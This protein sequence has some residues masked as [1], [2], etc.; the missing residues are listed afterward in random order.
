MTRRG[1]R[2]LE[3]RREIAI[4][5]GHD[6]D[7]LTPDV[8]ELV[9]RIATLKLVYE[10]ETTKLVAGEDVDSGNLLK[11]TESLTTLLPPPPPKVNA[12]TIKYVDSD[13][14]GR[15][16]TGGE[17]QRLQREVDEWRA[18]YHELIKKGGASPVVVSSGNNQEQRPAPEQPSNVVSFDPGAS[19][20]VDDDKSKRGNL[21]VSQSLEER[22]P[23]LRHDPPAGRW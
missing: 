1:E 8:R 4:A 6:P 3:L 7:N 11:L 9:N 21:V 18:K 13:G 20:S 23:S 17:E 10:I 5:R 22:Y 12:I 16:G 14:D 2:L 19:V 15:P